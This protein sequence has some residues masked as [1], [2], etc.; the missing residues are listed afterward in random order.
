[1]RF[2]V[3]IPVFNRLP[4]TIRCLES[5]S[6]QTDKGMEI[7]LIDDGSTDG[8]SE[9]VQERFPEVQ[10]IRGDGT[11]WW[12]GAV[13]LGVRRA[14]SSAAPDDYIL[15]VNNDTY[16]ESDFVARCRDA[17]RKYPNTLVGSVFVDPYTGELHG[18]IVVDWYTAK[19]TWVNNG[20]SIEDFPPGH[21]ESVSLLTG[22]G[23]IVPC[24]V[25]RDIGLYDDHYF[26]QHGDTEFSRRAYLNG[27]PLLVSYDLVTYNSDPDHA[28][29]DTVYR[30]GDL[31]EYLFGPK[32]EARLRTR[33]WF[34]MKT[35]INRLQG[36]SYLVCDLA[37]IFM[38]FLVRLR[39]RS[40]SSQ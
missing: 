14:L 32:A 7:I 13:N 12:S 28:K 40:Q 10:V 6:A 34:A 11:L 26:E 2:H 38:H 22:R 9:V 18:G 5:L 8:T 3:V 39:W 17:A 16:F 21:V 35:S 4:L 15:L 36:L 27:Y 20:K 30:P 25:Y 31:F 29:R 37:R 19:F 33:Y 24:K 23:V 1:M